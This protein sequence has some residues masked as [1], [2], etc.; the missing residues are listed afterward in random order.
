ML[1]DW[2]LEAAS[3][4]A[5]PASK[6]KADRALDAIARKIPT[7]PPPSPLVEEEDETVNVHILEGDV[8]GVDKGV[9]FTADQDEV[10]DEQGE[11]IDSGAIR[12]L[13]ARLNPELVAIAKPHQQEA[14][15]FCLK[16][17]MQDRGCVLAHSMGL[18]KTLTSLMLVEALKPAGVSLVLLLSPLNVRV[19]WKDELE[20]W[21]QLD[22][23]FFPVKDRA[24]LGTVLGAWK[25]GGGIL[26]LTYEL[27]INVAS[28]LPAA[29]LLVL[30]EAHKLGNQRTRS[31]KAVETYPCIRRIALT[32][33]PISNHLSE[34]YTILFLVAPTLLE[35]EAI[36]DFASFRRRFI[37]PIQQGQTRDATPEQAKLMRQHIHVLRTKMDSVMQRKTAAL[38]VHALP[39]K[40]EYVLR[41]PLSPPYRAMYDACTDECFEAWQHL[42]TRFSVVD[43]VRLAMALLDAFQAHQVHAIVFS[44]RKE[45]LQQLFSAR[46]DGFLYCGAVSEANRQKAIHAFQAG[47]YRNMYMTT[48]CGSLGLTLT[49]ATAIILLDC[50]WNPSTDTQAVFRAYRYGQTSPVNVYRLIAMDTIE[51]YCYRLQVTKATL[52]ANLIE[53]R[54]IN[55]QYTR[56]ELHH[57]SIAMPIHPID[58]LSITDPSL[59]SVV[60][61][62]TSQGQSLLI[63]SHDHAFHDD[64]DTMTD[65]EKYDAQNEVNRARNASDRVFSFLD[66]REFFVKPLEKYYCIINSD[67]NEQDKLGILTAHS[68]PSQGGGIYPP[69]IPIVSSRFKLGTGSDDA[70]ALILHVGPTNMQQIRIRCTDRTPEPWSDPVTT[71]V[72]L[73]P[74]VTGPNISPKCC[75]HAL[76]LSKAMFKKVG[77]HVAS[78]RAVHLGNLTL[79]SEWS[80]ASAPFYVPP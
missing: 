63:S 40:T 36:A 11:V 14:I 58:P 18:G 32:G 15:Q 47:Q 35:E 6:R 79:Y 28:D 71:T 78:A 76:R 29:H 22:I 56:A 43:K 66:G 51:D 55:R 13:S 49:R 8:K 3:M 54:E 31:F 38:L 42:V 34:Y 9:R 44:Q 80:E 25:R 24:S 2:A 73:L 17:L 57:D 39:P 1:M 45:P 7:P 21:H 5:P 67:P 48:Q 20:K 62:C 30:D 10:D 41:Y 46:N 23:D 50:S 53:E 65:E 12:N 69:Y 75:Y 72:A 61:L 26:N 33:T 74:Q 77:V 4:V 60:R 64:D 27:F 16:N 59:G 19:S 70:S 68:P 52:A 37:R